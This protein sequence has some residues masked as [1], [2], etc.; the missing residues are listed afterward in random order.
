VVYVESHDGKLR[1]HFHVGKAQ[2]GRGVFT[3]EIFCR[4]A[5]TVQVRFVAEEQ[6]YPELESVLRTIIPSLRVQARL[7]QS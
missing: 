5:E 2:L 4:P 1:G 7:S 3:V 6:Q